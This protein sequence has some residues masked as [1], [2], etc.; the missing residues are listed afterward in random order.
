MLEYKI[1]GTEWITAEDVVF[2]HTLAQNIM[3]GR[4]AK[5]D[6]K[7]PS[8]WRV[9]SGGRVVYIFLTPSSVRHPADL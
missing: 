4:S 9:S 3:S 7:A 2:L 5:D 6:V 1:I 8:G